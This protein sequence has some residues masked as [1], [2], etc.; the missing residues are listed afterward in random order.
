MAEKITVTIS[1]EVSDDWIE[2]CTKYSDIFMRMYC[3]YWMYGMEHDDALGWLC[4]EHDERK[5]LAE[6][7]E[8][9]EYNDIVSAWRAGKE[10]PAKWYRLDRATASKAWGEGVKR[11]GTNWYDSPNTDATTYDVVIQLALLSD[12]KYG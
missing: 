4:F 1:V 3:G 10:L 6:V 7:S 8:I 12:V 11:Y 2:F 5:T 9:P